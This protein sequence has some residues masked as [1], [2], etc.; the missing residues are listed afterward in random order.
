M[1]MQRLDRKR[2]PANRTGRRAGTSSP[3]SDTARPTVGR[4]ALLVGAVELS[5]TRYRPQWARWP[6]YA[7]LRAKIASA[8]APNFGS[9]A[10]FRR[11]ASNV[12]MPSSMVY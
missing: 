4:S 2:A 12:L 3:V 11:A 9:P 6:S 1:H 5:T 10:T 7:T 8:P